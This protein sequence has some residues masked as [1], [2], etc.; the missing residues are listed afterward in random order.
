[1]GTEGPPEA[2]PY[3]QCAA[4]TRG[5][6]RYADT[7]GENKVHGNRVRHR[8]GSGLGNF[9]CLI[10]SLHASL[11]LRCGGLPVASRKSALLCFAGGEKRFIQVP[12]EEGQHGRT[13]ALAIPRSGTHRAEGAL[14]RPEGL[15]LIIS[16]GTCSHTVLASLSF[17]LGTSRRSNRCKSKSPFSP[18]TTA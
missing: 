18:C 15:M 17:Y 5:P 10:S 16:L 9:L 2:F 12:S 8:G 7:F 6:C 1:M 4:R 3:S 11:H 14:N 13:Q